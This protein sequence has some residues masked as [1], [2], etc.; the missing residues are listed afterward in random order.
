VPDA[1]ATRPLVHGETPDRYLIGVAD[2]AHA[3]GH[4]RA[5]RY[6][7]DDLAKYP[8]LPARLAKARAIVAAPLP[9]DDLHSAWLGAIRA[10]ADRPAGALPSFTST[11]AFQDLRI[12]SFVAAYGQLKHNYVLT[13]A[14][15]YDEGAC[16]VPDGF[17]E[18][19]PAVY[20]ELAAYADR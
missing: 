14:Q 9:T 5:A 11:E 13:A 6:L 2:V 16:A 20:R 10:L 18:P 12:A 7:A 1:F 4:D 3:F 8:A 17:V 15:P 19:A